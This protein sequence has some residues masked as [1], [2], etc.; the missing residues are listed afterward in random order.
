MFR[1]L[2]E[3]L[4]D[5]NLRKAFGANYLD[6]MATDANQTEHSFTYI[7]KRYKVVSTKAGIV[8][9]SIV[10][11]TNPDELIGKIVYYKQQGMIKEV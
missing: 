5:D 1:E 7:N 8:F 3:G 9:N 2:L 11:E 10:K 6:Y 4:R